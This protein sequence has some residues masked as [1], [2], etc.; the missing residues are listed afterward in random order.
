MSALDAL[1]E[2]DFAYLTT[3]GR[4]TG[5]EHRI[6]IWFGL[7][8][9]VVYML[10]GGGDGSDWVRNLR[11]NPRVHLRIGDV[12]RPASARVVTDADEEG[13]ARRL[14]AA[15]YQGWRE[16]AALSGWARTALVVAVEPEDER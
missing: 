15:K 11:A 13:T 8:G 16:G 7:S 3:I 1:G 6:E 14:L 10:S 9:G 12:E 4:R 2:E 5:R